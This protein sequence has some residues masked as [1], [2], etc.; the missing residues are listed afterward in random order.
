MDALVRLYTERPLDNILIGR[1]DIKGRSVKIT[2]LI[3]VNISR[4]DRKGR[5]RKETGSIRS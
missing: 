1:G 2:M 4:Q 3:D 5:I